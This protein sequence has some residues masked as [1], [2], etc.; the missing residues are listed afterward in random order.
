MPEHA[1]TR[2][3][4]AVPLHHRRVSGPAARPRVL[5]AVALP[6]RGG[7]TSPFGRLLALPERRLVDRLL[8]G[9]ACIWVIGVMLGG[10]VAMQVSLLRLNSGISRAVQSASTLEVQNASLEDWIAK[11]TSGDLVR[12]AAVSDGMVDPQAGDTRYLYAHPATDPLRAIKRMQPPSAQ[13]L[14]VMAN[15][16]RVPGPSSPAAGAPAGVTNVAA[17]GTVTPPPAAATLA[18]AT[19]APAATPAATPVVPAATVAPASP[20]GGTAA[21]QG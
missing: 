21:P 4:A 2:R 6:A 17:T 5:P 10:I 13:A 1:R 3:S 9:R 7:R 18:S 8:R 20:A 19:P 15:H 12:A 11:A 16:G 14:A